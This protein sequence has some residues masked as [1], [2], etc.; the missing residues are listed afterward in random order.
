[1]KSRKNKFENLKWIISIW[2]NFPGWFLFLI[3]MGLI[4]GV[5][6]GLTPY[7]LKIIID[8]IKE[9]SFTKEKLLLLRDDFLIWLLLVGIATFV[10]GWY[11]AFRAMMHYRL[12]KFIRNKVFSKLLDKN[13]EFFLKYKPG[14][15][16][17]RL[18]DELV[19]FSKVS[20][21]LTSGIFR[22]F[23]AICVVAVSGI[24]MFSIHTG[25]TVVAFSV[26]PVAAV[27]FL[28]FQQK[29]KTVMQE[30]RKM[31]S[32]TNSFLETTLN[33]IDILKAYNSIYNVTSQFKNIL[34]ERT[35]KEIELVRMFA[36]FST[37]FSN[38]S[39]FGQIGVVFLGA[40]LVIKKTITLGDF[41][42][43]FTYLSFLVFYFIDIAMILVSGKQALVSIERLREI[44]ES[45]LIYSDEHIDTI[46]E[47]AENVFELKGVSLNLNG[48]N[49]LKN[50][51][52]RIKKGDW[53]AIV[54][55]IGSGKSL[56]LK[57]L[58][59]ILQTETG[60]VLFC[61]KNLF[62][63]KRS[64]RAKMIGYLE[65]EPVVFSQSIYENISFFRKLPEDK[66][67]DAAVISQ[68]H[69]EIIEF[70]NQYNQL[71]GERGVLLSGGQKQ[72]LALARVLADAP[73]I[74]LL[75][76]VTSSLD[77]ENELEFFE[78][79]R[80]KFKTITCIYVTHR[81]AAI[82]RADYI[83]CMA[84]GEIVGSGTHEKLINTCSEYKKLLSSIQE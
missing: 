65:T 80:R 82:M 51:N 70:E 78:F 61:Q 53:I 39:F 32:R 38:L 44:E 15:I 6:F 50:I 40:I 72:R 59:G 68:I 17:T 10:S 21:L 45:K 49:K 62:N 20:W 29:L 14:D 48:E 46:P 43:F 52:L 57:I 5:T 63:V 76:D 74:L 24:I 55:L 83:I 31:V 27:I 1:M 11:P 18:T 81:L 58:A 47:T 79:L 73:E 7:I 13:Y 77:A 25:L 35:D 42:A 41:F 67:R 54:G 23:N 71:V 75:D 36:A 4:S 19:D 34:K 60:E 16:L 30:Q 33:G 64:I 2:K 8:K 37:F 9:L 66:V 56:L 69:K 26:T 3:L 28:I 84:N 22:C 12:A